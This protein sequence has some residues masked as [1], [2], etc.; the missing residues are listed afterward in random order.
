LLGPYKGQ[1]PTQEIPVTKLKACKYYLYHENK[2]YNIP[3]SETE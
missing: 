1:N 2:Y 3:E